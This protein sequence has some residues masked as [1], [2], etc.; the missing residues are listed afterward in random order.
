[1]MLVNTETKKSITEYEFRKKFNNIILPKKLTN[2]LLS[3]FNHAL[4][5][6]TPYPEYERF[7]FSLS[8]D[9]AINENGVWKRQW[10]LE[11]INHTE[12]EIANYELLKAKQ[13]RSKKVSQITVEVDGMIFDGDETSQERMSRAITAALASNMATDTTT[14]WVLHDNS[15]ATPT[16]AQLATAL[17]LAGEEQ[18]KLWTVPYEEN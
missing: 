10:K 16:I 12:E 5:E 18:T 13:E 11:P 7:Y 6:E 17:R 9:D 15:V 1:M 14:T 8:E 2:E 3:Q 4:L